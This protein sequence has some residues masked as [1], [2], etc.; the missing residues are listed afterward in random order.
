MLGLYYAS[1]MKHSLTIG[2]CSL[3]YCYNITSICVVKYIQEI[4]V[5]HV[6]KLRSCTI[7]NT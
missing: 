2:Y 7:N 6:N 5:N 3:G 1:H 4:P